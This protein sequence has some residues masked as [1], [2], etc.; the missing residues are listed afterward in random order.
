MAQTKRCDACRGR[1][2]GPA[3]KAYDKR[4]SIYCSLKCVRAR[5]RIKA[6]VRKCPMCP[7]RILIRQKIAKGPQARFFCSRKC[8]HAAKRGKFRDCLECGKGFYALPF[9]VRRG[10]GRFCSHPCSSRHRRRLVDR[11]CKGCGTAFRVKRSTI[12]NKRGGEHCSQACRVEHARGVNSPAWKG[13][14]SF[15]PY[16]PAFNNALRA[17]V[18][19]RDGYCCFICNLTQ[20]KHGRKLDVHHIDYDKENNRPENLIS[21]CKSC[22]TR[23]NYDRSRWR[24]YFRKRIAVR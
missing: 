2:K 3:A 9:Y 1:I 16:P 23:T 15:N 4:K 8:L 22:H 12:N 7:T 11:T 6:V 18:R 24:G 19:K 21:L 5:I 17:L 13:G 10:Q 20:K 14:T